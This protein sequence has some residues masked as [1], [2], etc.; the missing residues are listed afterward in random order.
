MKRIVVFFLFLFIVAVS[1]ARDKSI[2]TL[3]SNLKNTTVDTA[4]LQI[5]LQLSTAYYLFNP[6]SAIFFAQRGYQIA[7]KYNRWRDEARALN[8]MA[9]GYATMGNY[10]K[11]MQ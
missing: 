10:A 3:R 9:S 11:S 1:N 5:L 4:R 6:D 2:D 8:D 7:E